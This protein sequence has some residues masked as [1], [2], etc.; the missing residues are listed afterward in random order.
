MNWEMLLESRKS[1]NE[2]SDYET[3]DIF[4]LA[5]LTPSRLCAKDL[6][7]PREQMTTRNS[8]LSVVRCFEL[9]MKS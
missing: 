2:N 1:S 5:G 4:V 9:T 6:C 7:C 8:Q 3:D